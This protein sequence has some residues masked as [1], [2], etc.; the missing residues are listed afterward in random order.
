PRGRHLPPHHLHRGP[1]PTHR[2]R[3]HRGRATHRP[4]PHQAGHVPGHG[5]GRRPR[6]G[7]APRRGPHQPGRLRPH[8]EPDGHGLDEPPPHHPRRVH[9]RCPH[10]SSSDGHHQAHPPHGHPP[11]ALTRR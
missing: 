9:P 10:A 7:A 1:A 6:R 11:A 8:L 2:R 5:I 3:G 4:R